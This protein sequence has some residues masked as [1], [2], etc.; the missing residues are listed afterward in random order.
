MAFAGLLVLLS[1][2][3]ATGIHQASPWELRLAAF[4]DILH[5]GRRSTLLQR[6]SFVKNLDYKIKLRVCSAYPADAPFE[7]LLNEVS[8]KEE[9]EYKSCF[10]YTGDLRSGDNVNFK[11]A[12]LASGSFTIDELPQEDATLVLVVHRHDKATMAVSFMSHVFAKLSGPQVALLDAYQGS[13]SSVVEIQPKD[14]DESKTETLRYNSVMALDEATYKV[15]LAMG[16]RKQEYELDAQSDEA[17]AIIRCGVDSEIL[18]SYKQVLP[19]MSVQRMLCLYGTN[20]Q[21]EKIRAAR[22]QSTLEV[23]WKSRVKRREYKHKQDKQVHGELDSLDV[24]LHLTFQVLG[25]LWLQEALGCRRLPLALSKE[26]CEGLTIL[27]ERLQLSDSAGNDFN[28]ANEILPQLCF[29]CLVEDRL[30]KAMRYLKLAHR[31][32][33]RQNEALAEQYALAKERRE[34]AQSSAQHAVKLGLCTDQN[35]KDVNGK[36]KEQKEPKV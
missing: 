17:Y 36:D 24:G 14:D 32:V 7:V 12:G 27:N 34:S 10:E 30:N 29:K 6:S 26:Y 28:V 18:K 16:D 2:T 19:P 23:P 4:N 33:E 11:V 1:S 20:A 15:T 9:L 25:T 3:L 35:D 31:E 13:S 22:S 21:K 8:I 5:L